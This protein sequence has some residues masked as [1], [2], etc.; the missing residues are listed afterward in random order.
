MMKGM[1]FGNK[2]SFDDLNLI[3]SKAEIPP[4]APKFAFVDLA[5]GDGSVDLTEAL[6]EV[7]FNN[8]E[9]T[10]TFTVL[11][12]DD[13]EEKKREVSNL[14]NGRRFN[15]TLDK[16][17]DYYWDGRC[18]VNEYVSDKMLRQIVVGAVV[19]PYKLKTTQTVVNV[20]AGSSVARTLQNGRRTVVPT[21]TTTAET[22]IVFDGN[23]FKVG[24]GTHKILNIELKEGEN[25]ITVTSS[26]T[27]KFTYQEGDL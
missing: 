5:G 25:R 19:A 24:A 12:S 11:P 22:T 17:P 1:F 7:K 6:G 23:T 10:F 26:G 21:I 13:F 15:I 4:A 3:L 16:D 2:H 18:S 14:L 27:T 9:C 20:P 8:R